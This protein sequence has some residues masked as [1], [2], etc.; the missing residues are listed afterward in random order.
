MTAGFLGTC[1][2]AMPGSSTT[3]SA[4]MF[5]SVAVVGESAAA[6]SAA[7]ANFL[8]PYT[9]PSDFTTNVGFPLSPVTSSQLI[10]LLTS[11]VLVK[12]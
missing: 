8:L 3:E 5:I 6:D 1:T 11:C 10:M 4:I 2:S 9:V 7:L 12:A